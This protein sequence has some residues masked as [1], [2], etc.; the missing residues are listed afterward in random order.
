MSNKEVTVRDMFLTEAMGECWHETK[1]P[2]TNINGFGE[3]IKCSAKLYFDMRDLINFSDWEGFGK[4][5]KWA[6]S[7]PWFDDLLYNYWSC[8]TGRN[9]FPYHFIDPDR[10]ADSLYKY[11][12]GVFPSR[13]LINKGKYPLAETFK[14]G[15]IINNL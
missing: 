14:N 12:T 6:E 10:F 13:Y 5:Y 4:L 2:I 9:V 15:D 7:Q 11:L 8:P 3:C 1:R